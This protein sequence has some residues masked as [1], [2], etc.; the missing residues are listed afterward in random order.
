MI[1]KLDGTIITQNQIHLKPIFNLIIINLNTILTG[2]LQDHT[3]IL[4]YIQNP[5]SVV[6]GSFIVYTIESNDYYESSTFVLPALQAGAFQSVSLLIDKL[7]MSFPFTNYTVVLTTSK[8]IPAGSLIKLIFPALVF[9]FSRA[10]CTDLSSNLIGS[11]FFQ[12]ILISV[13]IILFVDL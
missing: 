3:L 11:I 2:P 9:D 8:T 10:Y 4:N 5:L 13:I 1:F 6:T 12:N 7:Q